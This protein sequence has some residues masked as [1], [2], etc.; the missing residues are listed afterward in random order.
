MKRFG[1]IFAM[2]AMISLVSCE[3]EPEYTLVNGDYKAEMTD[4]SHGWKEFMEVT[5][6]DD[7]VTAV[8]YD[9]KNAGDTLKSSLTVYPMPDPPGLPSAWYPLLEAQYMD[10]DPV[11]YSS[12]DIDG[13][14]GATSTSNKSKDMFGLIAEAAKTGDTSTQMYTPAK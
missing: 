5:I 14:T 1:F 11:N 8:N 3:D 13:I 6:T 10:A 7:K 2:V 12:D 4:Y 9:A